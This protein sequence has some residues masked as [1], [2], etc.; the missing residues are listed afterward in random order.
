MQKKSQ[1]KSP[2]ALKVSEVLHG[3]QTLK[4]KIKLLVLDIDGVMTDGGVYFT[5]SGDE[6]KKFN[7]KDGLGIKNAVKAGITVAFLSAGRTKKLIQRRAD[8]LNVELVY[9]GHEEKCIILNQWIKKLKI[10]Y[11]EIAYI[12]DDVNDLECIEKSG[13]S[14]CPADASEKIKKAVRVVLKRKGGDACVREFI[15]KFLVKI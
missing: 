9:V 12:G 8:L 10:S 5:E 1:I 3:K 6:F 4:S 13:F 2:S 11:S 14:A 15:E 7:V